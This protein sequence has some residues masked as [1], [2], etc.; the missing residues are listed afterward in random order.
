MYAAF[1]LIFVVMM[2]ITWIYA[3]YLTGQQYAKTVAANP[4]LNVQ[5]NWM[6]VFWQGITWVG[7]WASFVG[8]RVAQ[9]QLKK[10][11]M[12]ITEVTQVMDNSGRA[13][14]PLQQVSERKQ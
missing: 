4:H 10:N 12:K 7:F 2:V 13:A 6:N 1:T 5:I 3:G 14:A 8:E 11:P 9:K